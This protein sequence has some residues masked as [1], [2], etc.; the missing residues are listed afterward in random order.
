[1]IKKNYMKQKVEF[2]TLVD[3]G[4]KETDT[5]GIVNIKNSFDK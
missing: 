3:Q 5:A 2:E 4:K 1:M